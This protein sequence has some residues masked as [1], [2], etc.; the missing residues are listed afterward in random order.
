MEDLILEQAG[1]FF[2]TE[3]LYSLLI[4]D[5]PRKAVASALAPLQCVYGMPTKKGGQTCL[6]GL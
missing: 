3:E 2:Y 6:K 5:N 1:I 4:P